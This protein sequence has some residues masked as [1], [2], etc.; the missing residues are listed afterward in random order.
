[1]VILPDAT[2]ADHTVRITGPVDSPAGLEAAAE[3]V[4]TALDEA[5]L[6]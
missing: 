1:M 4:V 6:L 3:V 5:G 2:D